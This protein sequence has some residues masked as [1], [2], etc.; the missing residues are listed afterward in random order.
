ME[1]SQLYHE[2]FQSLVEQ[3][4]AA[5]FTDKAEAEPEYYQEFPS[6]VDDELTYQVSFEDDCAWV[7]LQWW[8]AKTGR[9]WSNKV[10]DALR[11]EKGQ[12]EADFGGELYW[13]RTGNTV[14][15]SVSTWRYTTIND[16]QPALDEIRDWMLEA[17]PKRVCDNHLKWCGLFL[18]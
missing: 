11:V 5:G 9:D 13:R 17:L 4:G 10:H 15:F 12:I 7:Y 18:G 3:L 16:P 6:D 2:F 14:G 1:D 8:G